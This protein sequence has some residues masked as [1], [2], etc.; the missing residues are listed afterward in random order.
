MRAAALLF[1]TRMSLFQGRT[2]LFRM[3]T[4]RPIR[5][6]DRPKK[7]GTKTAQIPVR[8]C[9]ETT[10]AHASGSGHHGPDSLAY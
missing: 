6:L 2:T 4:A 8:R 10:P 9:F 7:G 1:R 5:D 3:R